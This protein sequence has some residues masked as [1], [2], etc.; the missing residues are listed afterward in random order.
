MYNVDIDSAP[1]SVFPKLQFALNQAD[2][3]G[4]ESR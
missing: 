3:F 4:M 2:M 1:H